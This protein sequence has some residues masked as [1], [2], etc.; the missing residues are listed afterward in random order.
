MICCVT[1]HRP[2]KFPFRYGEDTELHAKYL[3]CLAEEIKKLALEGCTHFITGGARGVDSDFAE[4]VIELRDT[5]F[6]N[7]KLEAA[8]PYPEKPKKKPKASDSRSEIISRC[9]IVTSVSPAYHKGCMHVRNRYMVDKSDII[10]AFWNG[11]KSGGTWNTIEYA[12]K[13]NREIRYVMPE[14]QCKSSD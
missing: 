6:G 12:R 3:E 2:E 7:I 5:Q 4:A 13:K 10:L 9:D 1:G 8:L 14:I 11:E